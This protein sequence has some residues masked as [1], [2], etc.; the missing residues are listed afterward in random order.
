M[1]NIKPIH[2]AE[3]FQNYSKKRREWSRDFHKKESMRKWKEKTKS[4]I[5]HVVLHSKFHVTIFFYTSKIE[6]KIFKNTFKESLKKTNKWFWV[7]V[8]G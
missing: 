2:T 3:S 7:G 1:K 4:N 6:K 5:F 8:G